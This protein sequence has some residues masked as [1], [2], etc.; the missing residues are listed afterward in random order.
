LLGVLLLKPSILL[1]DKYLLT[2][3]DFQPNEF[4][5]TLFQVIYYLSR[6]GANT[7]CAQDIQPL[8][9]KH[10]QQKEILQEN[11]YV[12]FI[13]TIKKLS[14]IDNIDYYYESV[15]K[16]TLIRAYQSKG[17]NI[18]RFID[19]DSVKDNVSLKEIIEYYEGLQI[20]IKK[21]FYVDKNIDEYKAG[22]GFMVVKEQFKQD[23]M[24]GA[25]TFS[26]LVN[27]ATRG[28]IKGQLTIYSA[29]SG[30]GKTTIGLYNLVKI[31]CP[32]IWDYEQ[33]KFIKNPCFMNCGVLYLQYELNPQY[34]IT[35]KIIAS[36]S[37]VPTSIILNGKYSNDE[38][39]RVDHAIEILNASQFYIVTMP[40]FTVGLLETYCKD[41]VYNH[42][43]QYI[44]FDYLSSTAAASSD[45]AK[46]NGVTTRSDEVLSAISSKLKDIAVELNVAM[47]SLHK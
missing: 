4:H 23:P 19:N 47:L 17:F 5:K 38:E 40:S 42:N 20:S 31:A 41:Y 22:N 15:K 26:N 37:G 11:K 16:N 28:F 34:E 46:N 1:S 6:H 32:E 13:D 14:N 9:E 29:A 43:V 45:I 2:K 44:C 12:E 3:D 25:T 36:I 33:N 35:P 39:S 24:F 27:T 7:I 8:I 21:D 30:S 10:E 18:D